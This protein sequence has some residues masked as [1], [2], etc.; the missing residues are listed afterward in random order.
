MIIELPKD[1]ILLFDSGYLFFYR[2]HATMKYLKFR[3]DDP[4]VDVV[5]KHYLDHME[6]QII[7]TKKKL[8]SSLIIFC[9]DTSLKKIWRSDLFN[10]YKGTRDHDIP[11]MPDIRKE[12]NELM[13][14]YGIIMSHPNLEADDIAYL[15]V[16]M[17]NEI[18]SN[19]SINI[20]TNDNDFLQILKYK[21]VK[22]F[23]GGLKELKGSGDPHIDLWLKILVGDP[24]DN[25]K[26]LCGKQKAL[27]LLEDPDALKVFI[28]KKNLSDRLNLNKKLIDMDNIP[29]KFAKDISKEYQFKI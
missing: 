14:K 1:G 21:N 4:P 7:K 27:K 23:N 29:V 13:N 15:C 5:V 10:E 18:N 8:K 9:M 22:L 3:Y 6:K 26:G 24:S 16:K 2:F 11:I 17:I 25:I 19:Q 28:E 20:I 12:I